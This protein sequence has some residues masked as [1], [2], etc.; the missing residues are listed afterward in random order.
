LCGWLPPDEAVDYQAHLAD[1]TACREECAL[2]RRID[3]LLAD[4][5][6]AIAPVPA[7]LRNRV[8][9]G[10]RAARR[11]RVLGW[12][13]AAA[14][15]TAIAIALGIFATKKIAFSP[16]EGR[17]TAQHSSAGNDIPPS[18][19]RATGTGPPAAV[20]RVTMIDPSSAIVMPME[21]RHPNVTLVRVFPTISTTRD[22]ES[23]ASPGTQDIEKPDVE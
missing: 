9:G 8:D 12:A 20:A 2:Q 7:R 6:V 1:C 13:G 11:R 10:I 17:Q 3:R 14:A 22:D 19:A 15:A 4:G 21:S 18:V 16:R 23:P 5:V